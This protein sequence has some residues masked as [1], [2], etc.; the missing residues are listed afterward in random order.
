MI[1]QLAFL[2][3]TIAM[4]LTF[5]RLVRGPTILDRVV[6]LDLI[7][8]LS[9]GFMA[10]YAIDADQAVYLDVA[11]TLALIAFLSTLAFAWFVQQKGES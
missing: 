1:V 8:L 11:A 3:I 5:W 7:A 6:A 4:A 9:V 10:L 2:T